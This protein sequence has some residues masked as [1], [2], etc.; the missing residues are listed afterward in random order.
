MKPTDKCVIIRKT[1]KEVCAWYSKQVCERVNLP[2][3]DMK[4]C[5][6]HDPPK[7][8]VHYAKYYKV[9]GK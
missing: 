4:Q 2:L 6:E 5:P 8:I 7:V 1:E 9:S 3:K